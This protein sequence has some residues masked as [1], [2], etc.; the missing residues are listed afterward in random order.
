M[1]A[2]RHQPELGFRPVATQRPDQ[3]IH[4]VDEVRDLP[5]HIQDQLVELLAQRLY[6][7]MAKALSRVL[8]S[9]I[10]RRRTGIVENTA[11][12]FRGFA[13]IRFASDF[14]SAAQSQGH[15]GS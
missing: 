15:Y 9:R 13:C 10:R 12:A 7:G 4:L 2:F 11:D 8:T 3:F 6:V 1:R 5:P 14:M